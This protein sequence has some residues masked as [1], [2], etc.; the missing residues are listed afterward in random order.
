[1]TASD[2]PG[3]HW[4]KAFHSPY[5]GAVD[6]VTPITV[7]ID[8]VVLEPDKTK[9]SKENFNTAYYKERFIRPSEPMKPMILNVTN[10]KML[11]E[12]TNSKFIEDWA[13]VTVE[14]YVQPG[15]HMGRDIVEGLRIKPAEARPEASEDLLAE[16]EAKTKLGEVGFVQWYNALPRES[17]VAI[18]RSRRDGW[19]ADAR[20]V[21]P[22][23]TEVT[24][25]KVE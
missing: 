16:G 17:K 19:L 8:R 2:K 23:P 12:M 21:T 22:Q 13:G 9:K 15:V 4:R 11:Q 25:E 24:E 10:C 20:K 7:T 6:I 1:M 5:L 14:V 18:G 3:T